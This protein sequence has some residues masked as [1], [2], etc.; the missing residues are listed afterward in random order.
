[1]AATTVGEAGGFG[2]DTARG[3]AFGKAS[4]AKRGTAGT[5]VGKSP[6]SFRIST[7]VLHVLGFKEKT[8]VL[9]I[10]WVDSG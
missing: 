9:G 6:K 3:K 1:M 2:Q 7:P 5:V 4:G 8:G 10:R